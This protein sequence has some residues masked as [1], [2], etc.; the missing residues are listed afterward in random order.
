M[1]TLS[2]DAQA[3]LGLLVALAELLGMA[4]KSA[5]LFVF[6]SFVFHHTLKT[7]WTC[8]I[9]SAFADLGSTLYFLLTVGPENS[10][11]R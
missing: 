11:V 10:L 4:G 7:S 3:T 6:S 9:L 2:S 1:S 8:F 5:W